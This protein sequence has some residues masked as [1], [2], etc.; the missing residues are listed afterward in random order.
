MRKKLFCALF[1]IFI[2]TQSS[3]IG[4]HKSGPSISGKTAALCSTKSF[5]SAKKLIFGFLG[6]AGLFLMYKA[7]GF[8]GD[9]YYAP[10]LFD[11]CRN[12][13]HEAIRRLESKFSPQLI[14]R[15]FDK[16]QTALF[17]AC[18]NN[19][20]RAVR[21]LIP[22]CDSSVINARE[23]DE[24]TPLCQ[25]IKNNNLG[26]IKIL[27]ENGSN[28]DHEIMG[29]TTLEE[30]EVILEC[31]DKEVEEDPTSAHTFWHTFWKDVWEDCLQNKLFWACKDNDLREA[32]E[33]IQICTPRMINLETNGETPLDQAVINNNLE[34]AEALIEAGSNIKENTLDEARKEDVDRAAI[35]DY[36]NEVIRKE[37]NRLVKSII[38]AFSDGKANEELFYACENNNRQYIKKLQPRFNLK[39]VSSWDTFNRTPLFWTCKNNDTEAAKAIVPHCRP[40]IINLHTNEG[41][42]LCQAVINNN[43]EIVEVLIQHGAHIEE[44]VLREARKKDVDRTA[45]SN[46]L[47]RMLR[48]EPD[49]GIISRVGPDGVIY[50]RRITLP[51]DGSNADYPLLFFNACFI[52][53]RKEIRTLQ[54]KLN[55]AIA[56]F[57]LK[58]NQTPLF[59]TCKNNNT[60]AAKAI[61]SHCRPEIINL[62]TNEGTPLH[63]AVM[64][65]NLEIVEALVEHGSSIEEEVLQEARKKDV[66]RSAIS[67]YLNRIVREEPDRLI[68]RNKIFKK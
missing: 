45:I 40:E 12:N 46:Y 13:D 20:L 47:N 68:K 52:N 15:R 4:V 1:S 17:W 67:N 34:M 3:I 55:P 41:T 31:L 21:A 60:E 2:L 27:V 37:P 7:Y 58:L 43:L 48:E 9:D 64:H 26:M 32:N 66:D 19:N 8:F 24:G 63:Q 62:H 29:I 33:L 22:H 36:L 44:D 38:M 35:S 14:N 28:I 25:A 30:K 51:I 59:W 56:E 53:D 54:P 42:P 11:A 50:S 57:C 18:K 61:V 16:N 49:R 10:R 5:F 6:I 65:N 23:P 39:V